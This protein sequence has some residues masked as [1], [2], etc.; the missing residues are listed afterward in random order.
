V[1]WGLCELLIRESRQSAPD[2][3]SEALHLADLAVH[4][5][6]RIPEN[7]P[8]EDKWIYQLR[9]LA[10]AAHANARR[11]QGDLAGAEGNFGMSDSWWEAGTVGIGDVFGYEPILLAKPSASNRQGGR[12]SVVT[13]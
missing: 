7:D 11:V 8:F 3:P 10:W 1:S 2:K 9:S 4:A 6:D 12:S 5:A 13:G